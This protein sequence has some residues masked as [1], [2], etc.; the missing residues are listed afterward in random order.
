MKYITQSIVVAILVFIVG[1]STTGL[2]RGARIVGGGLKIEWTPTE[3]DGTA[4]L[5][6]RTM[7]KIVASQTVGTGTP[8]SFDVT[9]A[10]GAELLNS[11]FTTPATNAQFVLYYVPP[12]RK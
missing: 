10:N 5:Y 1:C 11:V 8:F 3:D 6:E 9:T 2:P 4:I 7:R 12:R